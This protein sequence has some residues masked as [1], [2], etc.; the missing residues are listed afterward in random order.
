MTQSLLKSALKLSKA[1]RILLVERLWDSLVD[2]DVAPPLT[3]AQRAELDKRL[4]RVAETGPQGSDWPTV[5]AR[6]TRRA[7]R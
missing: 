5:K 7:K 2:E 1:E 3:K 4:A 6:V